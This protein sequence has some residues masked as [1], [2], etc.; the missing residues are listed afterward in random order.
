M[1]LAASGDLLDRYRQWEWMVRYY[2]QH[3]PPRNREDAEQA[4]RVGLWK[5]LESWSPER[6]NFHTW[7]KHRIRWEVADEMRRID[8]L[9]RRDRDYLNS[10]QSWQAEHRGGTPSA[11]EAAD[12]GW[13][14]DRI[15]RADNATPADLGL[16]AEVIPGGDDP[17]NEVISR[18]EADRIQDAMAALPY[19]EWEATT[20]RWIDD[21]P[22][23]KIAEYQGVSEATVYH[24]IKRAKK[25]LRRVLEI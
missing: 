2:T 16:F 1:A 19:P 22:P 3:V 8:R 20:L 25:R 12:A 7:A 6:S 9:P 5:A 14:L 10:Y 21:W 17:A 18:M 23:T 11:Q 4:A 13:D 15:R 24:R